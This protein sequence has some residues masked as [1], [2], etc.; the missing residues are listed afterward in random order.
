MRYILVSLK[1]TLHLDLHKLE[2][3]Y[4]HA[5]GLAPFSPLEAEP[6]LFFSAV[7]LATFLSTFFC[8]FDLGA[9]L[10]D[11]LPSGCV[12]VLSIP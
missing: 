6:V 10:S 3:F 9:D 8:W 2:T 7:E 11:L 12:F 5:T 4:F 1:S